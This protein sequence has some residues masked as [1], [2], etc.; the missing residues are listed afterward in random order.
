M[1]HNASTYNE[2]VLRVKQIRTLYYPGYIVNFHKYSALVVEK[3]I[4]L[5]SVAAQSGF[6]RRRRRRKMNLERNGKETNSRA[7]Y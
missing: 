5:A 4:P 2:C 3:I 1:K 6:V 7:L